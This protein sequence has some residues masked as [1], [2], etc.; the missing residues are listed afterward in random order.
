MQLVHFSQ[1]LFEHHFTCLLRADHPRVGEHLALDQ[2]LALRHVVVRAEGRSQELFEKV[3]A[4]KRIKRDVALDTPH[5]L[6]LPMIIARSDLVATVPHAVGVYHAR[7][8]SNVRAVAPPLELPPIV[9]KQHWHRRVHR[10][11]R[12]LWLRRLVCDLFSQESDE[13]VTE[14]QDLLKV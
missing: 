11:A 6:S 9:L 2:F 1:R 5:Y 13:W 7:M 8:S 12:C 3:L 4:A 14:G 10:D